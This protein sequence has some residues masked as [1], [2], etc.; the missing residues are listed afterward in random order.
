MN[1][2]LVVGGGRGDGGGGNVCER[3]VYLYSFWGAFGEAAIKSSC[4]FTN[5]S[6][7]REAAWMTTDC[8]RREGGHKRRKE[9]VCECSSSWFCVYM[10]QP[11]F[12]DSL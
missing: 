1:G 7:S 12:A 8:T 3:I 10:F 2:R 5:S 11:P 9:K 4:C 6:R